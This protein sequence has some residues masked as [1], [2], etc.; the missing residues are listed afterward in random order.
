MSLEVPLEPKPPGAGR[1][2]GGY[3]RLLVRLRWWVIGFWVVVTVGSLVALPSLSDSGDR[4]GLKGLLSLDTP[5]VQTEIRSVQLFGFPL[6]ARTVLVQRDPDG[7]TVYAQARTVTRALAVN[8]GRAGDVGALQGALPLTNTFGLF[9]GS[10]EQDTTALTYLFFQPDVS[11]GT[12]TRAAQRYALRFFDDAEDDIVG[13][14]GSVPARAQQGDIIEESL[15]LVE[16]VTLLAIVLIVGLNFRSVVAPV[17]ALCTT[18]VAFALTLRL[19]GGVTALFGVTSPS[20]LEPVVVALLLGVVTDYVVFFCSALRHELETGADRLAA[21]GSATAQFGPIVGVAGLAVAAGTAALVVA[22]SPFF[23]ALGPALVVTVLIGLVVSMT[24]VPALMAVLGRFVFWPTRPE[25]VAPSALASRWSPVTH[26]AHRPRVAMG[27]VVGATA[28]LLLAALPLRGLELGV[29]FVKSLPEDTVVRT[30]ALSAEAGFAPGILSPTVVL[31]EGPDVGSQRVR[32][33]RL[34]DRLAEQPGVAGVLG[35]G[36]QPVPI[37]AGVL[38]ARS[39]EAARYLLV[40]EDDPLGAAA[41]DTVAALADRLP[42]LVADSGVTGVTSGLAGDSA[43]AAFLVEQTE[44]D[45]FRI[46]F[47]ALLA[48]LLMLVLFLRALVAAV[49]L[50]LATLLSLGA[51]LGLTTLVFE[52]LDP[53][54]GLTFYVPFAAAVLLLAF[55]SDYNIFGVGHVWDEARHRPLAEALSVAIPRTTRAITAAGLALAASF[56]LL[57]L[58][59]LAP[60]HQLAFAMG[61]GILVDVFVVRSLLMPALLTVFGPLSAWPSRHL[62]ERVSLLRSDD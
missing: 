13:I 26:I 45:L 7:M 21:A 57:A 30:A 62:R 19:S 22:E 12:Q 18:G 59:P 3:G 14:T 9:P 54:Q 6:L 55:G 43:T 23:R 56:G 2:A 44:R 47:A 51:T 40:L 15:P 46:A 50:L 36:S 58:V 16:A 52:Q 39:G 29:S 35:P 10:A 60:F 42:D 31:L 28:V 25:P 5:A 24:L 17:V 27:V 34:G 4:D 1:L 41:V 37:E 32:L 11:L 53:G 20:E 33:E 49:Y 8:R 61:V 38:L 48:N